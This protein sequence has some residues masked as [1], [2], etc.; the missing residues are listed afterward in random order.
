MYKR[1]KFSYKE[2]R[3]NAFVFEDTNKFI[4]EKI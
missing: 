2:V 1:P 4:N 3:F